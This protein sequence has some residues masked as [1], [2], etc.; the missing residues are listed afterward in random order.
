MGPLPPMGRTGRHG[1]GPG[2]R[3]LAG[4]ADRGGPGHASRG[5]GPGPPRSRLLQLCSYF[6]WV[7]TPKPPAMKPKPTTMFQFPSDLTGRLPSVT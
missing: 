4:G 6:H 5:A 1:A 2:A 7:E 3:R